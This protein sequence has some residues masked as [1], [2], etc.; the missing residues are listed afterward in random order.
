MS[1]DDCSGCCGKGSFR[2]CGR[3]A[4]KTAQSCLLVVRTACTHPI[5]DTQNYEVLV[6]STFEIMDVSEMQAADSLSPGGI[7][8]NLLGHSRSHIQLVRRPFR[9][10]VRLTK[11][12]LLI[13]TKE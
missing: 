3:D 11:M 4:L 8:D 10:R 6:R 13:A 7:F 2:S 9:L 12:V 5:N 1:E